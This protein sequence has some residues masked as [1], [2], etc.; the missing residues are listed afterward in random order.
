MALYTNPPLIK[1]I[2]FRDYIQRVKHCSN[3]M[4][5][6]YGES[7]RIACSVCAERLIE[8]TIDSIVDADD[9]VK[10]E[11]ES[12]KLFESA[13]N[14]LYYIFWKDSEAGK[15]LFDRSL[16]AIG[17]DKDGKKWFHPTNWI[18]GPS[19][20]WSKVLK[21]QLIIEGSYNNSIHMFGPTFPKEI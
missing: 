4:L 11:D 15:T 5:M 20:E 16:A 13:P 6:Y 21:I 3:C 1:H 7:K 18:S 19:Y 14:G 8:L 2:A 9:K 10:T 17:T 12:A